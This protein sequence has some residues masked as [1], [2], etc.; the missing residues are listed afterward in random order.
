MIGTLRT[1]I[2]AAKSSLIL[3]LVS[4]T[5]E[6][7]RVHKSWRN[8]LSKSHY[9]SHLRVLSTVFRIA[10]PM[11]IKKA[12]AKRD[13]AGTSAPD[14]LASILAQ[15]RARAAQAAMPNGPQAGGSR[16][17]TENPSKSYHSPIFCANNMSFRYW[18][19][20]SPKPPS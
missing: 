5:K 20:A 17:S 12:L 19:G 14:H 11:P 16:S 9:R 10:L 6:I 2:L 3:S 13:V 4:L 1:R 7:L 8:S 15:R 18:C